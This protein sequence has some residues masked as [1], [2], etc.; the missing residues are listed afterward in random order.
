MKAKLSSLVYT[1]LSHFSVDGNILLFP[2]LIT[3]YKVI[4]GL[5]LFVIGLMPVLYNIISGS[6]SVFVGSYADRVDKDAL[7]LSSGLFLNGISILF[8][9]LP[10]LMRPDAYEFMII[11]AVVL[12]VGQSIYHPL[13]A[14]ILTHTFGPR[15]SPSYLGINGSFGSLGRSLFPPILIALATLVGIKLGLDSFVV[16]FAVVAISVYLGLKFFRRR[17]YHFDL[18]KEPKKENKLGATGSLPF[19]FI[20]LI[21]IV[22]LRSM[23]LSVATTY[24]PTYL[25]DQFNSRQLMVVIL[26]IGFFAPVVGQPFFGYLTSK[27]GGKFTISLTSIGLVVFF[28]IF[29]F[30]SKSFISVSVS[31]TLFAFFAYTGFPVLLGYVSQIIPAEHFTRANAMVWGLGNTIGGSIGLLL[32]DGLLLFTSMYRSF[33]VMTMFAIASAILLFYL[34][35]RK[36]DKNVL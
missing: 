20:I 34:P 11:G 27:F 35:G 24:L 8:F 13:G 17:D 3:Y 28:I 7:I 2:V 9:S 32:F 30:I 10:L 1:S 19:F 29:L 25:D 14:T 12:G 5:S 31:F 22:F 6:L 21:V 18:K 16:Y 15:E 4:P 26:G 36:T 23:F 33:I